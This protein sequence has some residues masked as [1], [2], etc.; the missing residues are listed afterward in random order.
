MNSSWKNESEIPKKLRA[1]LDIPE[2]LKGYEINFIA[3]KK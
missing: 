3:L 2:D 1:E